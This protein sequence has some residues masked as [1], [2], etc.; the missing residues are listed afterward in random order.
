MENTIEE[1]FRD[2]F[3]ESRNLL[4]K[5]NSADTASKLEKNVLKFSIIIDKYSNLIDLM[6]NLKNECR[7]KALEIREELELKEKFD[8]KENNKFRFVFQGKYKN[9]SWGEISDLEE[10]RDNIINNTKKIE[11]KLCKEKQNSIPWKNI[12]F[13]DSVKLPKELNIRMV[14]RLDN[15]PPAFGWYSGDKKHKE[16]VYIRL[17][18]NMFIRI[19]FPDTIDGT[20]QNSR[21][22][23]VKCKYETHE[24]C[25]ENRKFLADRYETNIRDCFF[26]HK[27]DKYTKVGTNFRC[28][29]KPRFGNH[30]TLN[31]DIE[32]IKSND[33]K[34]ILMYALSDLFTC[35]IWNDYHHSNDRIIFSD[36]EI[37]Q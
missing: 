5:K 14:S 36:I 16:G 13:M 33:I 26:A 30:K 25:M 37:C 9:M 15:L 1:Y 17:P 7:D 31:W 2:C 8:S 29:S 11:K 32:N 22:R 10:K 34:I 12:K 3:K 28:P 4:K 20:Q 21:I 6:K 24:Q 27:N 23:T 35:L 18:E 19:P